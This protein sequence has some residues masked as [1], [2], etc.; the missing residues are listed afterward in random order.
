MKRLEFILLSLLAACSPVTE[1]IESNIV[2]PRIQ[3]TGGA[4]NAS[5]SEAKLIREGKCLYL[6]HADGSKVLPIFATKTLDWDTETKSLKVDSDT[7]FLGDKAAYGG[8]ESD[9]R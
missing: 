8:G 4:D 6:E 1:K 7:Y 5:Y 9:I 3:Y 2:V